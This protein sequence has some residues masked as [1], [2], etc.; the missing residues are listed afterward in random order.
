MSKRIGTDGSLL[1]SL[2]WTLAALAF[3]VIPHV[4][5][6]PI[7]ATGVFVLCSA[8][9]WKIERKRWRLP[10]AWTRIVL[11]FA[12]FAGVYISYDA[13]SGVGPGSALLAVMAALKLLETKQRRDQFVL[14]F[15]SIFLIMSSLLREQYLWS[16]PYLIAGVLFTMTAWLHMSESRRG[17]IGGSLASASRLAAYAVPLMLAMWIFFPRIAT[18]FWA[19]PI[20]TSAATSG[21][22]DRMSPGDVSSLSLSDSVAFRVKFDGETPPP[23]KRYWRGFILHSFNGRTWTG[24]DPSIDRNAKQ[25]VSYDGNP[26]SYQVTMEPT[27]QHSVF[28]LDIPEEWDLRQTNMGPQHQ[29]AR[30]HPIN[31]RITYRATSY[32]DSRLNVDL[33]AFWK[34]R[35]TLLPKDSNTQA[36]TLAREMREAAGSDE[37][38]INQVLQKFNNEEFFYTL[39]PPALGANPVDE[40]LFDSK[41]GFCE[42]YASAFAVL[43]RAGG[44]PSRVVL[45]YQGGEINPMGQYMIVR[46]ADAHAWNEVWLPKRG[47]YR[48]DPTAAVAPERIEEGRSS[49]MFDGIGA[50]WGLNAPSEFVYQLTLTWDVINT[51]W[52]EWVLAYGPDNQNKFM[53][54]LGMDDPDWR[55]M[56]LSLGAI[57]MVLIGIISALLVVRYRPP[58]KDDAARLYERFTAATGITP[59]LGETPLAYS[60]RLGANAA[61]GAATEITQ[62]YLQ[63]RYG[64]TDIGDVSALRAAVNEYSRAARA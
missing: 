6:L 30:I 5:F 64:A 17:T 15:I 7:W 40:F 42:H 62:L 10:P 33:G 8:W 26:V 41:R 16:L 34:G 13:V 49:A 59:N 61:S 4:Q 57:L 37:Q 58:P 14:L 22:S 47:W 36:V 32:P 43:M 3:S 60:G 44:I 48:I 25:E 1:A 52:N 29:L 45:G 2:P 28:A 38:F 56:M 39:E 35:Y 12:C 27:R 9:R 50:S 23:H 18:P 55:K 24:S 46:Q 31:Q 63:A 20:D 51:R 53:Q 54:W 11:A 21:L 19:V